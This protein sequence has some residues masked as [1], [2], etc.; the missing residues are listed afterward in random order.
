M[1]R[2][3]SA[4]AGSCRSTRWSTSSGRL[5]ELAGDEI[6]D[7]EWAD[8][9]NSVEA[10]AGGHDGVLYRLK[11]GGRIHFGP[12]GLIMRETF[13]DPYATGSHDYLGCPEIVQDISRCYTS[14]RGGDL[15]RRF[16]EAAKGCIVKFRSA[17]CRPGD[18]KAALWYA[19]TKLRDGEISSNANYAFQR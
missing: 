4:G 3:R 7:E 9:R 12:F 15:E 11:T 5:R 19:Y 10:G 14:A 2:R 1:T 18:V 8:F 16:C 13:F 17:N 6:T